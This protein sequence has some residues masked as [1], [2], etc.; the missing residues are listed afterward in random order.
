MQTS[1]DYRIALSYHCGCCGLCIE[2]KDRVE[3]PGRDP[4]RD[5]GP[6][7]GARDHR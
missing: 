1:I 5:K 7:D 6:V 2:L 4:E 3:H